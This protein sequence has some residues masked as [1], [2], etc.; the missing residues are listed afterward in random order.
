MGVFTRTAGRLGAWLFRSGASADWLAGKDFGLSVP[1]SSGMRV[2][3]E[4]AMQVTAVMACVRMLAEDTSKAIP[5]LY[6]NHDDGSRK[7]ATD[8]PLRRLLIEPNDWQTW[9]EF[10]MQM[11]AALV[12]RGNGYAVMPR[13]MAGRVRYFVPVN[14]DRVALWEAPDGSLFYMVTRAGL[15]ETA[16]LRDEPI[17]VPARDM[18]HLKGLS[19]NGLIGMSPIAV[20]R[21]AIG[22][23][24]AQEEQAGRWMGNAARP[25][26]V[27]TTDQRLSAGA[28]KRIE[29]DWRRTKGGVQNSG[30]T[31]VL[32]Q[33]LK[34]QSLSMTSSD[35]EFIASRRFQIEEIT[36]IFRIPI[37]MISEVSSSSHVDPDKRSQNYVNY[38]LST[39][40]HIWSSR[41]EKTFGL[42]K[43][44]ISVDFDMSLILRNDRATRYNSYRSGIMGGF[45]TPNEA[46]IDDGKNPIEGGDVLLTPSNS[47]PFGSDHS[48][49]APDGAGH[50]AADEANPDQNPTP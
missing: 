3:Q 5:D 25:S 22:L 30:A 31:L 41:L 14:P 27:L 43:D 4:T 34:F 49:T 21:E 47:T 35:L 36:R 19:S 8:H 1:T 38:S 28:A 45:I 40:T 9:Q 7:V 42:Q 6:R 37:A 50:P 10:A 48:G 2:S 12:M 23:A 13:D 33:G 32:E 18:L 20:A 24:L 46:R 11:T 15:H 16:V 44:G 26:G 29:E 17:L 39:L